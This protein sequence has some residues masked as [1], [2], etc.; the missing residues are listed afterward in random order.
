V[1]KWEKEAL[2]SGLDMTPNMIQWCFDELRYKASLVPKAPLPPPPIIVFNGNVVKSD[3]AVSPELKQAIQDAVAKFE[4]ETPEGQKDWH[5]GS[6]EQVW[7]LV[8]PSLFPLVYGRSHV[9]VN[10]ES[11]TLDNFI[12]RCGQ[13]DLTSEPDFDPHQNQYIWVTP[14]HNAYSK[15]F[16]WLPCEVD[17]SAENS[18]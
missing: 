12:E 8:H 9:L 11:T 13:G 16:Q 5:P 15:N 7:D 14:L 3:A 17:I 2:A 1:K 4:S 10:G 6:E 18:R